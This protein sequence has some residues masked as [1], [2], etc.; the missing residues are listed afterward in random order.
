MKSAPL[1]VVELSDEMKEV[2]IEN[3]KEENDDEEGL[4]QEEREEGRGAT[5][6]MASFCDGKSVW[7]DQEGAANGQRPTSLT[8]HKGDIWPT[9]RPQTE[10]DNAHKGKHAGRT[11][12]LTAFYVCNKY[13][14]NLYLRMVLGTIICK[15]W[16]CFC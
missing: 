4:Q 6:P 7:E 5:L 16:I 9:E 11:K 2:E 8:D 12:L 14:T 1:A 13:L 10:D 15:R 3:R